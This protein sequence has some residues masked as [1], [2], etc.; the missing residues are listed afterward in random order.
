[1]FP[2]LHVLS[3]TNINLIVKNPGLFME[4]GINMPIYNTILKRQKSSVEPN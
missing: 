1:M 3:A 4:E 2:I